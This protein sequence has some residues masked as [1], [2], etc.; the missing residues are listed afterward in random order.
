MIFKRQFPW[1][2]LSILKRSDK[3]TALIG[4]GAHR[5]RPALLK[6]TGHGGFVRQ[7]ESPLVLERRNKIHR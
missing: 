6:Q 7:T 1:S 5:L 2:H 4:A 3:G